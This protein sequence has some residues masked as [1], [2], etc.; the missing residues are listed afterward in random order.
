[1]SITCA[2]ASC[3]SRASKRLSKRASSLHANRFCHTKDTVLSL[4]RQVLRRR[5]GRSQRCSAKLCKC[6]GEI[7]CHISVLITTCSAYRATGVAKPQPFGMTCDKQLD[8]ICIC[9]G[10]V[11]SACRM[12]SRK[13]IQNESQQLADAECCRGCMSA[14]LLY[15]MLAACLWQAAALPGALSPEN[16][17]MRQAAEVHAKGRMTEAGKIK[18]LNHTLPTRCTSRP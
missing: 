3:G 1:M 7:Q 5:Y 13:R 2:T 10:S 4:L 16:L 12:P 8:T 18:T 9:Q 14:L 11:V 17:M 15:S 6:F